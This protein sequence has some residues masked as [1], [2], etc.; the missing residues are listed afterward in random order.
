MRQHPDRP[1]RRTILA[2]GAALAGVVGLGVAG[3]VISAASARTIDVAPGEVTIVRFSADGTSL[4]PE[5]VDKVVKSEAEWKGQL[6]DL[7]FRVTRQAGTERA[8]SGEYANNH[9][10]GL[11]RCICCDTALYD[12][13][14]KFESGT[15]WPSFLQP[16]AAENVI[17]HADSSFGMLRTAVSC[18]RCEAHL[19]HVFNDGPRPTGLRYCM[20]SV[21]LD[22]V[23]RGTA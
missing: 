12:S 15:G 1:T 16:I 2:S 6:S 17:E 23:P 21:A 14:T 13:E 9:D 4:G 22:F 20:N 18:R 5:T 7:A 3:R 11:Y 8:F 10:S 19:G